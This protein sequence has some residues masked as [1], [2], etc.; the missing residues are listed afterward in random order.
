[1]LYKAARGSGELHQPF[2]IIKE[3]QNSIQS[4]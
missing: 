1:L 4:S 3:V 2:K